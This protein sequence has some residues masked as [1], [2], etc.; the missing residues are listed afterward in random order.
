[1]GVEQKIPL[2]FG[3][4]YIFKDEF[5]GISAIYAECMTSL[6]ILKGSALL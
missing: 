1:M 2:F 3:F 5:K 6:S 4:S